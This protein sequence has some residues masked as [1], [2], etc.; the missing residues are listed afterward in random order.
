MSELVDYL[1]SPAVQVM[2]IIGLAELWKKLELPKRWI[3]L[4]DLA[5]GILFGFLVYG[6]LG[7]VPALMIGIAEG[8]S[9]CGLFSGIKNT[10]EVYHDN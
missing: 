9:A 3:P 7:V 10:M 2:L 6:R 4:F 5:V 8:L 1:L